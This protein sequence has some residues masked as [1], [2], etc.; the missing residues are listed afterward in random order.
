M[1]C[2]EQPQQ[3]VL[4]RGQLEAGEE[5]VFDCPEP[6]V[7]PPQGKV[8]FLLGRIEPPDRTLWD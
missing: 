1:G 6:V 8:R 7:G 2:S 4:L 5:F 3:V